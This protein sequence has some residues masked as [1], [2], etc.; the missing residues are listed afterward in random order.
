[1]K[2][3]AFQFYASDF[4][5]GTVELSTEDVGAYIRLLCYQWSNGEIP[6]KTI[7]VDRIAGCSVS[8]EVLMKF[9]ERK[10]RRLE[11]E[12]V[13]QAAYRQLQ[14]EK[15]KASA[16]ARLNRASTTVASTAVNTRQQP[17]PPANPPA[18]ASPPQPA[19]V[20][21][22]YLVEKTGRMFRQTAGNLKVISARLSETGVDEAGV[23]QMIDRMVLRW[24]DDPKM[25]EYLRPATLFCKE[26]FD[27]YY[28][29][30]DL[31]V[32][33]AKGAGND[34]GH[35]P[36]FAEIRDLESAIAVHPA[37]HE[38]VHHDANCTTEK[39]DE[40]D[41]LKRRLFDMRRTNP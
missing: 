6:E 26:K 7:A 24:K 33:V 32:A 9:P 28:A 30:K 38:S 8:S 25:E 37:N 15:G 27:G 39:C 13:K 4:L 36:A 3:P 2:P 29:A 17:S 10:N 40:L 5:A 12:R 35:K 11:V 34:R 23:L 1:M 18:E 14:S 41:A 19:S 20:I 16:E 22:S 31:P 21:L